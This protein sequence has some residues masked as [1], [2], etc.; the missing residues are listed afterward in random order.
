MVEI[1]ICDDEPFQIVIIEKL[2]ESVSKKNHIMIDVEVFNN[3]IEIL[4]SVREGKCFDIIYMDIEM[5]GKNGLET[6]KELREID[7]MALLIYVTNYENYMLET[8]EYRP[9]R[10]IV[11]PIEEKS[12]EQYFLRAYEEILLNNIYFNYKYNKIYYKV[13]IQDIMY[14]ESEKRIIYIRTRRSTNTSEIT[15]K[16]YDKLDN[17]EKILEKSKMHFLRIHQSFLVN[18]RYISEISYDKV[19]LMNGKVL[20]ISEDRRKKISKDYCNIIGSRSK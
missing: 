9:F 17:I 6:A 19:V 11:K 4:N 1:A 16:F 7:R 8:F 13:L 15:Y 20:Y 12:F 10:F 18:F 2:L 3:G 14:F 5:G